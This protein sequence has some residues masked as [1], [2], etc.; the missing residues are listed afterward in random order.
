MISVVTPLFNKRSTIRR[1]V[2]SVL[3]QTDPAREYII[4]NDGSSDDSAN[5]VSSMSNSDIKLVTQPNRGVSAARN[6][7]VQEAV[8][9]YVAFVDADDYWSPQFLEE[10]QFLMRKHPGCNM[11]CCRY[12]Y[13]KAN[14]IA[15]YP[16]RWPKQKHGYG[17]LDNYYEAAC[18][19]PV[20]H[21]SNVV[22]KRRALLELGGFPEGVHTGEDMDTWARLAFDGSVCMS[23]KTLSNYVQNASADTSTNVRQLSDLLPFSKMAEEVLKS[24]I[25]HGF[26]VWLLKYHQFLLMQQ[27]FKAIRWNDLSLAKLCI[28]LIGFPRFRYATYTGCILGLLC[29]AVKKPAIFGRH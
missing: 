2:E 10:I 21:S 23:G 22:V 25:S 1:C 29:C 9:K 8:S 12:H 14:G 28:R 4:V 16:G 26:G 15:Y 5:I 17:I 13:I 6:R 18:K 27:A 19:G 3:S 7:G 20:V 24:G 11:Y